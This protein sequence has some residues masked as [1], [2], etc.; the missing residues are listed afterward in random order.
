MLSPDFE[1]F[2]KLLNKYEVDYLIVGGYAMA[3]HGKPRYTGDLDIWIDIS[4]ANAEKMLLV[5]KDFGF[6]SLG[7]RKEDFLKENLI[8]Q[9]GY[10]PLRI[11]ILT[12]IDGIKFPDAY[13]KKLTIEL[14]GTKAHYIGLGD[15][16]TNKQSSARLIDISDVKDLQKQKKN[17]N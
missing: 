2:I 16:I 15:L 14:E 17:K 5:I 13:S 12:S 8:N 6:S 4:D 7:F 3:F 11:D 10:P 1:D 9:I